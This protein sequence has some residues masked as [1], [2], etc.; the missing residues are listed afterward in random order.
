MPEDIKKVE[1]QTKMICG[2]K[3]SDKKLHSDRATLSTKEQFD[4]DIFWKE[5]KKQFRL[6]NL[7][8]FD[9]MCYDVAK[10]F[11]QKH[12][13]I[14]KYIEH[15]T[16]IL[17]DE[18][19]DTDTAQ[20]DFINAFS[21]ANI[22]VCGD[23]QQML[24]RFRGCTNALI[25][26][27]A[28][29][30]QWELIKLPRNYRSTRQIVEYS[31][32]IFADA[33]SG[34]KYYLAGISDVEGANVVVRGAFPTTGKALSSI[35]S[36][37]AENCK[38]NTV[39][40]LCRTNAEVADIRSMLTSLHIPVRGKANKEE[41]IGILRSSIDSTFC[42]NWLAGQL[43]N[44]EYM[45]Y[46]RMIV[47]NPE[48]NEERNFISVFGTHFVRTLSRIYEVRKA[49]S[50]SNMV[51]ALMTAC[52]RLKLKI[53]IEEIEDCTDIISGIEHI[54][55]ILGQ[56]SETG[57]YIGTIHSVKGLEYDIVHVVGVNSRSFPV[58]KD[59]DNMACYY[60]AC[61]R[62]K[63]HLTI[64]CSDEVSNYNAPDGIFDGTL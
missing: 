42:V 25:K 50:Q 26:N 10:L 11:V 35:A 14:I 36:D 53:S 6:A 3:L 7:I 40:I 54:I 5:Y 30:E 20:M 15:Y 52:D 29:S 19:Q 12:D 24:Y 41:L 57:V 62:A 47:L 28:E 63:K 51:W 37:M 59:E 39:A 44:E 31:N 61:T 32:R 21:N 1:M 49:L 13:S 58:Y 64:W 23:P 17:I 48:M 45:R 34:S 60:V 56:T 38:Q 22:F 43:P 4:Y 18:F 46:T 16:C 8:T 27:L 9:I 33:W 55:D 2:T